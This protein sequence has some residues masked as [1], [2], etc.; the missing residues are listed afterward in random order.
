M[1]R[2]LWVVRVRQCKTNPRNFSTSHITLHASSPRLRTRH[3]FRPFA[4]LVAPSTAPTA[5]RSRRT[6]SGICSGVATPKQIRHSFG[7][8]AAVLVR[9]VPEFAGHVQHARVERRRDE[10]AVRP[11]VDA[12]ERQPDVQPA[13]G[14]RPRRAGHVARTRVRRPRASDRACG[15]R[16]REAPRCAG[17]TRPNAISRAM[18][19][20]T[21]FVEPKSWLPFR[22][23][24]GSITSG[25]RIA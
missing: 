20:W 18:R 3:G 2:E 15:D 1:V 24:S 7:R 4:R 10:R 14:D 6:P 11:G 22:C 17:R 21:R 8:H 25:G 23:R 5:S 13:R 9:D 19:C 16:H 12:V